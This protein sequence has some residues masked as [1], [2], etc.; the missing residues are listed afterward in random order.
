MAKGSITE[1]Y[2]RMWPRALFE[3]V[4]GEKVNPAHSLGFLAGPGVYVLYR[5]DTPHYIGQAQRLEGRLFA[6]ARKPEDRYYHFLELLFCFCRE[7]QEAARRARSDSDR[8]DA[9]SKQC[10][11]QAAEGKNAPFSLQA[12][13]RGLQSQ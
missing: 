6:H 5:N 4:K 9:D 7:G 11:A 10:K 8:R 2:V 1:G 3:R 12:F 13:A